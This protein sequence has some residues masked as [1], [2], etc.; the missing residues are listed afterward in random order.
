[1]NKSGSK[2]FKT[3]EKMDAALIALIAKK[4]LNISP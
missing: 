3:A 1:M 4:I 2:Y